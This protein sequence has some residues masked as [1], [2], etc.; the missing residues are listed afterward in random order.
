MLGKNS[1]TVVGGGVIGLAIA[2][3]LSIDGHRVRLVDMQSLGRS[4]SWAGAGILPSAA[5]TEFSDPIDLLRGYSHQLYPTWVDRLRAETGIDPEFRRCGGIYL[6]R[7][8]AEKAT[9]A[10]QQFLWSDQDIDFERWD[11]KRLYQGSEFLNLIAGQLPSD[12]GIWYLPHECQIR[13][14]RLLRALIAAA[15]NSG[16]ELIENTQIENIRPLDGAG[17]QLTTS[18]DSWHCDM[19]CLAGGSWSQRLLGPLDVHTGIL[20]VRGQ[21]LLYHNPRPAELPVI[22]EGHRYLVTRS[23]GYMLAGSCEEEV[24]FEIETTDEKIS[25]LKMWVNSLLP[26][27]NEHYFVK[28][29]AGLRP[30]S[31]DG[32]P[33]IGSVAEHPQIIVASGH[34]RSGLH[35]APATAEIVASIVNQVPPPIDISA[36]NLKRGQTAA[37]NW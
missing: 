9:L 20:P 34:Y 15:S 13:N 24:G 18:K 29:W 23:D 10:A 36:F 32:F 21:M 25:E 19:V 30:G 4:A 14:P 31:F 26:T 8:N 7:T 17:C 6:G 33:Y 3:R 2:W 37:S 35:L 12:A 28:A 16:I 1:I 11:A 5:R 22:N 27:W